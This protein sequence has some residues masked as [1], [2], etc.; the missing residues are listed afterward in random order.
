MQTDDKLAYN[1]VAAWFEGNG[2]LPE[3]VAAV[4]GLEENLRLQ[5]KAAQGMKNLRHVHGALSG[6]VHKY[7]RI[8]VP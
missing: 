6:P 5:D 2:I 8:R 1:S 4:K 7:G 3:A